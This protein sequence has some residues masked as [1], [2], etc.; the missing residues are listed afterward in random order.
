MTRRTTEFNRVVQSNFLV[1]GMSYH[2]LLAMLQ[3]EQNFAG[4]VLRGLGLEHVRVSKVAWARYQQLMEE[5]GELH[6][7][8]EDDDTGG[9]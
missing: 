2:L 4:K 6:G 9:S 5:H 8:V 3:N 7:D 1:P